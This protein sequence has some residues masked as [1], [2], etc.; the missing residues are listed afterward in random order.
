[1]NRSIKTE[2]TGVGDK[3]A[4][5]AEGL[6][7]T[8]ITKARK[9]VQTV[10]EQLGTSTDSIRDKIDR[11]AEDASEVMSTVTEGVRSS[12]DYLQDQ[13]FSGLMDD[14]GTLIKRYPIYAMLIGAGIGFTLI[15]RR[16]R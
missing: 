12:A 13:G 4:G 14:V 9:A 10:G 3:L 15:R 8:A 1:M 7:D 16:T 5:K 11:T 6:S 2:V